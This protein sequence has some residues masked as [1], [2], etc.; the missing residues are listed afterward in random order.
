MTIIEGKFAFDNQSI[1]EWVCL[2]LK[3]SRLKETDI[4]KMPGS[5][6]VEVVY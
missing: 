3:Y 5:E 6:K 4:R 2:S 1:L